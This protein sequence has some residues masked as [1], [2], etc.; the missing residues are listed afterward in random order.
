MTPADAVVFF[1]AT[2]DLARK[3]IYPALARLVKNNRLTVP[4]VGVA[5]SR[6]SCEKFVDIVRD[7]IQEHG[8]P[9]A[10]VFDRLASLVSYVDG[11]YRDLATFERLRQKLGPAQ[12]VL[13]YMA[14]P[15]ALFPDVVR[16]LKEKRCSGGGRLVVEKPFG[17]DLESARAL[18]RA[19][20]D[21]FPEESVF[22]IDHYLGKEAVENLSYFRFA[23]S[24]FEP[25]WHRQYV[26]S[27]QITMAEAFGVEGRGSFY[28]E[29]GAIRDVLQNHLV[30][31]VANLAMD[32]PSRGEPLREVRARTIRAMLPLQPGDVV[33]GQFRGY[34]AEPGVAEH[35]DVETY[36]AVRLFIDNARWSGVPF[37]IRAGKHLPVTAT[38]A[39]VVFIR[40]ARPALG[41]PVPQG[42][43]YLRSRLG[44]DVE[45]A[46]GMRAKEPGERMRGMPIEL[47]AHSDSHKHM[48]AYERL[49]GAALEGDTELFAT[50]DGVEAAWTVVRPA[51]DQPSPLRVYETGTWGP[52][53]ADRLL[54]GFGPWYDPA[55][56]PA[57]A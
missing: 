52:A 43:A 36:C 53:E 33:R 55:P 17:R 35:S 14:I 56:S 16:A 24:I 20:L 18:N 57:G 45:I 4:V 9:D 38:E 32:P 54:D 5:R 22:R 48:M 31:V 11:D 26:E 21:A 50:G 30:Q 23:N 41:D 6:M 1:G 39:R 25:L 28:E 46:L 29:V 7:S 12:R 8:E 13:Y 15:P 40:P 27:V 51:L 10:A 34:L 44:P 37:F 47:I 19:I 2:G 42:A 3:K 49:L